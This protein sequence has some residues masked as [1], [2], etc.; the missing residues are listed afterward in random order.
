MIVCFTLSVPSFARLPSATNVDA[1]PSACAG[2]ANGPASKPQVKRQEAINAPIR[3]SVIG[4][5]A[6]TR[7]SLPLVVHQVR[8]RA[9][10]RPASVVILE[11]PAAD[12]TRRI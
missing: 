11:V 8:L 3:W 4:R 10:T 9:K 1:L 6:G 2:K 12:R 5:L 7:Y